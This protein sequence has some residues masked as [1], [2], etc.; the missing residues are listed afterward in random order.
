MEYVLSKHAQKRMY[1][2]DILEE[3]LLQALT[4]P[5]LIVMDEDDPQLGHRLAVI[6]EEGHRVLRVVCIPTGKPLTV[7]TVH[8]DRSM[9]GKL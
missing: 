8:F 7:V 3:W 6:K 4:E 1:E 5:D 2:R 9:K